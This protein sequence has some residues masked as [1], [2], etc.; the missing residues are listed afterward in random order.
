M[1]SDEQLVKRCLDREKGATDEFYRRFASKMFGVCLRYA[2]SRVEAED[3]LQEGFIKVF[4]SLS[5]FRCDGSLEGWVRRIIVN[6]SIN[7]YRQKSPW[8]EDVETSKDANRETAEYDVVSAL[9][10]DE[11]LA[12]IQQLPEG[13]RMVFNLYVIEGFL[14]KEIAEMLN[15]SENTSK[16]QLLKARKALQ[17][18]LKNVLYEQAV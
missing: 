10:A 5:T 9:S 11:L 1:L 15:I 3:L 14:H 17:E 16:S 12:I 6:N 2:R 8:F 4:S 18:K 7:Y 13:Y